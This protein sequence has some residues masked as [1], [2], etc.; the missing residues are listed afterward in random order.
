MTTA[1]IHGVVHDKFATTM[2]EMSESL[3]EREDETAICLTALLCNQHCLFVG[4]PGS[5][6]SLLADSIADWIS[7]NV[8]KAQINRFTTPEELIGPVDFL[9]LKAGEYRRVTDG[10]LPEADVAFLDE[11]F[12]GSSAILNTLL[13]ILNERKLKNGKVTMSCPLKLCIA[14]SNEFG[15]EAKELGAMFDRFLFRKIVNNVSSESSIDRLM[16]ANDLTPCLSTV[17][18]IPD[19][20]SAQA[21][22]DCLLWSL[23]AKEAAHEIRKK[24]TREG[25][26]IGDRRLRQSERACRAYA[27]LNGKAEVTTDDLEI[28]SHIWWTNPEGQPQVVMDTIADIAKPSRLMVTQLLADAQQI[29][30]D[31]DMKDHKTH[32]PATHK[33]KN[34]YKEVKKFST[35][36]AESAKGLI[37]SMVQD[38][39]MATVASLD[40]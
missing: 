28:L 20:K 1:F 8:F 5:A 25:I 19:L 15:T 17:L 16:F 6:K 14:A 26:R 27:W 18:S 23:D 13:N 21:R 35:P 31:L 40:D 34:I 39:R 2:R 37:E 10:M 29:M 7:G 4:D 36:Q 9:G 38:I 12:K 24:L 33:L 22:V 3:I 11:V 32:G 30:A